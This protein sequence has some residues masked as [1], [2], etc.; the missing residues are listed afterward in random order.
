MLEQVK[1]PNNSLESPPDAAGGLSREAYA[2]LAQANLLRVR[3]QWAEAVEACRAA[4]RLAPDSAAAQSLL[5]DIYE[6]QA[7]LDDAAQW[8]RMA[9]DSSP[10]SAADRL[11]LDRLLRRQEAPEASLPV[12]EVSP[13]S[14]SP[15]PERALRT[16]AVA[17]A[18][19]ILLVV[20]LAFVAAHRHATLVSLGLGTAPEVR[21]K[22]VVVAPAAAGQAP[23]LR[24]SAEQS[25]LDA[26]NAAPGFRAQGLTA[27]DV[28]IDPRA[29]QCSLTVGLTS[30]TVPL[31]ADIERAALSAALSAASAAGSTSSFTV[32]CILPAAGTSPTSSGGTLVFVGDIARTA[33][34]SPLV[35]GDPVAA[36]SDADIAPLFT[37]PWWSFAVPT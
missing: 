9:L 1:Q 20:G 14:A 16:Q 21:A 24:D 18:L 31:R 13:H 8:Y 7:D 26:L 29:G 10:D 30:A 3:G 33:L 19:I 25:L 35:G 2:L 34:P 37:N 27:L 22:P 11:K 28:Q 12:L 36:L 23:P 6:N 5:G 17:A 15:A 32:R 4:L